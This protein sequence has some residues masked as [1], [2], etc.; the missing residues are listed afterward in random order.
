MKSR[1]FI[2]IS[3]AA[4]LAAVSCTQ[5]E[6]E[7]V[8]A[9]GTDRIK[10]VIEKADTRTYMGA[11]GLSTY[12]VVKDKIGVYTAEGTSNLEFTLQTSNDAL[13]G[14]FSG[15]L[16]GETPKYAYY[17][18][19]AQ[20]GSHKAVALTLSPD[21][22]AS[23]ISQYDFKASNN[24][25]QTGVDDYQMNF[26]GVMSVIAVEIDATGTPLANSNLKSVT[27]KALPLDGEDTPAVTGDFHLN[28]EDLSTSFSGIT[29]DYAKLVWDTPHA[30]AEGKALAYMFV[31]P[32]S[33]KAGTPLEV[34][35]E[36]SE[37]NE[38]TVSYTSAK[39]CIPNA[40]YSF[41][42]ALAELGDK[43][44]YD[45]TPL[46]SVK[47]L[48]SA[49][50]GKLM[51]SSL[52][53]GSGLNT[54][55]DYVNSTTSYDIEAT[56]D[57]AEGLWT[58]VIPYLHDFSGLVASFEAVESGSTVYVDGVEQES[59]VTVND[60]NQI[61]TYEVVN[62]SGVRTSAKV[63][64]VNSGLPVVTINGTV[65]SKATDF[66]DI[67]GTTTINIDGTDYTCGLR[68]R[69]N[70]TQNMPKKPYAF[71]L[72]SKASILGMPKHKRWV[73]LANWLDRTMLRNDLAFYLAHQT[74][75]WAPHGQHVE[76]V[77]NG[78]H[79]GNYYLCEQIKIDGNRLDI[80][81]YGWE[82]LSADVASPTTQDVA[83]NIGYLL[84]CDTAA[85][86]TEIYFRVTSPVPFY[87]YIKDP[88]DASAYLGSSSS[89]GSTLA[90]TYIRNYFNS[91]GTA[92]RNSNWSTLETLIDYKSFADHWIFTEL[93][94]NQESKHPKSFYMY[95]DAGGKLCA[96]PAWDYDWGTF[97]PMENIGT[98]SSSA[99]SVKNNYTARY[100][101][102]YQY[103]FN[104]D[105]FVA[106]VKE[107][108]EAMKA[109]F[110]SALPYLDNQMEAL[111]LSDTFNH[112]MWPCTGF[113]YEYPNFDET[114]SWDDATVQMRDCLEARIGWLDTEI[115]KL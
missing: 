96:G 83:D 111:R 60:F 70:S 25:T 79:V 28:L 114:L 48:Q 112:A 34:I 49:N 110:E 93:T 12:W 109:G 62:A 90:Y 91:V 9:A 10:A 68:L 58:A 40:R 53:T 45:G 36:T 108:W 18:Y 67:E 27:V 84:E 47:F 30:L 13:E 14:L 41:N 54:G 8:P 51:K 38:A 89:Y 43:V 82:N 42:M 5:A 98:N 81:D 72:D 17:P 19:F 21:Q 113:N 87:V 80:A 55:Q 78:V 73:L 57:E 24:L 86:E 106:V 32:E 23:S 99:G 65:Y 20:D 92:L 52:Y 31:N 29:Y 22:D 101:M 33:I 63:K 74:D 15:S 61:V 7:Q 71:K 35:F 104:D 69:G 102:W 95:K 59:G 16:Y 26:Q 115:S 94:E 2:T 107:R 50:S 64:V 37:G 4:I 100:T 77:L 39:N 3:V 97:I 76:V 105:A 66:D 44:T 88:G 85:D 103:L 56:Y 75:T 46:A 1:S 6:P 11:D